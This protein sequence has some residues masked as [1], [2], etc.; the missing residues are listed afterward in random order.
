MLRED[1]EDLAEV[2]TEEG[3]ENGY[4]QL[5]R[6][7]LLKIVTTI[8]ISTVKEDGMPKVDLKMMEEKWKDIPEFEGYYKISNYGRVKNIKTNRLKC[9][10]VNRCGYLRVQ[11]CKD[12]YRKRYFVHRLVALSFVEGYFEGAVVNHI[13]M[14]RKN[15]RYDNLEWVTQSQNQKKAIAI[16]GKTRGMFSC[17]PYH[18]VYPDGMIKV[19]KNLKECADFVGY[20][21]NGVRYRMKHCFGYIPEVDGIIEP[22][23]I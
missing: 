18:I 1:L 6:F 15:N 21:K 20:S 9:F 5:V 11:L 3:A 14:N 2:E 16:R 8:T 19:F 7:G 10:D 22:H 13:D 4:R 23:I 12:N 17:K